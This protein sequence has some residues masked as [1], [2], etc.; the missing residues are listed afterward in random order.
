MVKENIGSFVAT[1]VASGPA[2]F[3]YAV[4]VETSDDTAVGKRGR[5][6]ACG[7]VQAYRSCSISVCRHSIFSYTF[8]RMHVFAHCNT[9][10]CLGLLIVSSMW[11]G[12][13]PCLTS[14]CL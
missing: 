12:C 4:T 5:I 3:E 10:M 9:I 11:F 13:F 1:V 2:D 14:T 8:H 7:T 6:I